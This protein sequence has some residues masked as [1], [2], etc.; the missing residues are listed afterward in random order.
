[1]TDFFL[2]SGSRSSPLAIAAARSLLIRLHRHF[3]ERA[4]GFYALGCAMATGK[5]SAVIVTSGTAVGNLL[6]AVME[7]H[8]ASVPLILLTADRPPELLDSGANQT[9][10][11]IKIFSNFVRWQFALDESMSESSVRSKAAHGVYRS[12]SPHPGPIQFNCPLREP[13]YPPKQTSPGH[14]IHIEQGRI[15]A[16]GNMTL[17]SKGLILIGKLPKPS[18]LAP[19]LHL[20][21]RMQWPVMADLLSS[22]RVHPTEEQVR[23]SDWLY[24]NPAMP[25]PECV[26][27]FGERLTSKRLVEW[28]VK[29]PSLE[30]IHISPY[31]TWFDFVHLLKRRIVSEI[32]EA[33]ALFQ[34]PPDTH[35]LPRW[36]LLDA[37]IQKQLES[38]IVEGTETAL[39]QAL[40]KLP[41]KDT[42]IYLGNGMPIREADWFL[43][44]RECRGFYANRGV[45]GIDGNI[46]TVVGLA[47]GLQSPVL[48][49]LGDL[50]TLHD[51]NSLA[52]V[53]Q[54]K[55]PIALIV[56]NNGGGGMFSHLTIAKDPQ[57]EELFAFQHNHTFEHAAK[58]FGL[59]YVT[60]LSIPNESCLI[61]LT[62]CR[63][64]NYSQHQ[65]LKELCTSFSMDS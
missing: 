54:S 7:A 65:K 9:T 57:F 45:S 4:L 51:L 10:D 50:T 42:A 60:D 19:I 59:P 5:P 13:L 64:Q 6:P 28:L 44:P 23:H 3:D 25:L 52:L 30:Y 55:Y 11:Q 49:F 56:S 8:H 46:A 47:E 22:A 24:L 48:A 62:T 2:A 34:A 38:N 32:P 12:L 18:D 35:W 37:L 29:I 53:K 61:E 31:P 20:A 26:L 43:F 15:I 27:H 36:K 41:L 1:V 16:N 33:C 58:L 17:P 39:M 21:K 40:S 14:P 63:K